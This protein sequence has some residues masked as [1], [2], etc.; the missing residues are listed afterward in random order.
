MD[1]V[2]AAFAYVR[3]TFFPQWQEG[4]E[5]TVTE[6]GTLAYYGRCDD[7][8]RTI[9]VRSEIGDEDRLFLTLVHEICHAV[10]REP[11]SKSWRRMMP[12]SIL[13]S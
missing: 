2:Q 6:D 8:A 9:L 10:S 1:R 4:H 7:A 11:H 13:F 12:G 3:E 5:W